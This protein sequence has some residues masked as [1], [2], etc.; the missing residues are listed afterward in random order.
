MNLLKQR[1]VSYE[2]YSEKF[3]GGPFLESRTPVESEYFCGFEEVVKRKKTIT[4]NKPIH[5][6]FFILSNSKL[7]N[8]NFLSAIRKH[9]IIQEIQLLYTDTDS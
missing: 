9:T 5:Y 4:D 7:H 6:A 1:N 2:K 3:S 8:L